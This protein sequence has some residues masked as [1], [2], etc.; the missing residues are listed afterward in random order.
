MSTA[1]FLVQIVYKFLTPATTTGGVPPGMPGNPA[2]LARALAANLGAGQIMTCHCD[3]HLAHGLH[4][5]GLVGKETIGKGLPSRIQSTS[6]NHE[7]MVFACFCT[8]HTQMATN[9]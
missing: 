8:S 5:Q 9:Q 4:F 2:V 7:K 1:L 6:P 3:E